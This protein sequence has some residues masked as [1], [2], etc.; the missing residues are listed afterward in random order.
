[1][2]ESLI[3]RRLARRVLPVRIALPGAADE[4][5]LATFD[6]FL[7]YAKSRLLTDVEDLVDTVVC[8]AQLG[9]GA[10]FKL[11]QGVQALLDVAV[12]DVGTDQTRIGQ[13]LQLVDEP[14]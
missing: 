12:R 2:P 7:E 10:G 4:L 11:Q 5:E 9:R 8:A 14:I 13:A 1:M 6:L 3:E